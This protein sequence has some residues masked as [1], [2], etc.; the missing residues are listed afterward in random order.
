MLGLF[1]GPHAQF[2]FFFVLEV[3]IDKVSQ[4]CKLCYVW[5]VDP[6]NLTLS[7]LYRSS[8]APRLLVFSLLARSGSNFSSS[9]W[10]PNP[11]HECAHCD[12][13]LFVRWVYCNLSLSWGPNPER[14]CAHCDASLFVRFARHLIL[15]FKTHFFASPLVWRDTGL[16][17]RNPGRVLPIQ[18]YV[19]DE[20]LTSCEAEKN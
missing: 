8:A 13:S 18:I 6:S 19:Y 9:S 11:E 20:C 14:E 5:S 2:F 17:L 4:E 12:A 1:G 7:P 3:E 16:Y 15:C 10:R